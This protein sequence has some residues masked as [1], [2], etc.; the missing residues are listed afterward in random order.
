MVLFF[1]VGMRLAAIDTSTPA[2]P[3]TTLPLLIEQHP[4]RAAPLLTLAVLLPLSV[5]LLVPFVLVGY[6]VLFDGSVRA[7]VAAKPGSMVQ[8]LI[9]L[10]FWAVLF[11]WPLKRIADLMVR[12]R[13]IEIDRHRV[14]VTE[15]GLFSRSTWVEPTGA[16]AGLQHNVRASLSGVRHELILV[17]PEP[18]RSVLVAIAPRF[19]EEQIGGLAKVFGVAE[20]PSRAAVSLDPWTVRPTITAVPP[21]MGQAHA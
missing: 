18:E 3:F 10:A 4:S 11:A 7:L 12:G 9:G 15:L 6:H 14:T 21:A 2:G 16:Y 13:S 19:T 20:I 17:H 8:I 1:G 5:A